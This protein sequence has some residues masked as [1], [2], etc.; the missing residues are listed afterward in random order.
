MPDSKQK[1]QPHFILQVAQKKL[2]LLKLASKKIN[3]LQVRFDSGSNFHRLNF[4]GGKNQLIAKAVG[5][6]KGFIPHVT[7]VT[8]GLA[9]DAF[10]LAGF[11]CSINL[12]ERSPVLCAL[13]EDALN[14]AYE[15]EQIESI[16]KKMTLYHQDAYDYLFQQTNNSLDIVYIDP[17]FPEKKGSALVKVD[18][19]ILQEM[20]G[21]DEDADKILTIAIE[22]AKYRVVVKRPKTANYLN[23]QKPQLTLEAKKQRYDIYIK[24]KLPV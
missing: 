22:K 19:Q 1:E 3:P 17:M 13:L 14:Q 6:N 9:R 8:A 20:I 21:K 12:V 18:M 4:G 10:V 15:D 23:N 2:Q 5:I 16:C 7:D 11:G 24:Q